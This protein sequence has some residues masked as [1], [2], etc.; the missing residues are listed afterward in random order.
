MVLIVIFGSWFII[1][2]RLF[3]KECLK[4]FSSE[5]CLCGSHM[6]CCVQSQ[7]YWIGSMNL[8]NCGWIPCFMC[9]LWY[10]WTCVY[11]LSGIALRFF[12]SDHFLPLC[13]K[14]QSQGHL[15]C[16]LSLKYYHEWKE[17]QWKGNFEN[18]CEKKGGFVCL[19]NNSNRVMVE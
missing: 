3:C 8:S 2:L 13:S 7:C 14:I 11:T 18:D 16:L 19:N 5:L 10:S 6:E 12:S 15:L 17:V 9:Y 4:G 1:L